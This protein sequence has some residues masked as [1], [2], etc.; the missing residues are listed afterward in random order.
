MQLS[1]V[2]ETEPEGDQRRETNTLQMQKI[3]AG[4]KSV[5]SDGAKADRS[6]HRRIGRDLPTKSNRVPSTSQTDSI[7]ILSVSSLDLTERVW[8]TDTGSVDGWRSP[9][10]PRCRTGKSSDQLHRIV[11]KMIHWWRLWSAMANWVRSWMVVEVVLV[12]DNSDSR[13]NLS[14]KN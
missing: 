7:Q 3:A 13:F 14:I 6:F 2:N 4:F 12:L 10:D 9:L 5:L 11:P 1:R 8:G